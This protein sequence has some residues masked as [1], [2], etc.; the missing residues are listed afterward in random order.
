MKKNIYFLLLFVLVTNSIFAQDQ[1]V[2]EIR[3]FPY[4]FVPKGWARC[5]GQLLPLSQNTALFS[6]LGTTYGGDGKTNFALPDLRGAMAIGAGQ[7]PGLSNI[8]LGQ[9][10][11]LNNTLIPANLPPH[12]H[13]VDI[14][15]NN[16]TG[17][18]STPTATSSLAAP[19]QVFRGNN[20]TVLG[21]NTTA[22]NV[23]LTGIQTSNTGSTATINTQPVLASVYCIALSGIFPPR[24]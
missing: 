9:K 2:A 17:T 10:T 18:A 8:D 1:F 23:T 14:K 12:T 6:L 3:L 13:T 24:P 11:P 4:N 21:Y 19:L 7:G 16:T 15:V 20:R 22:T 5:E